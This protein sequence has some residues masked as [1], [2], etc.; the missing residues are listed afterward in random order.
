MSNLIGKIKST[1]ASTFEIP[2]ETIRDDSSS[3][4]IEKWDSIGQINLV[5]ALEQELGLSFTMDEILQLKD[6]ATICRVV[7]GKTA[8]AKTA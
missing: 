6:I 4:T 1:I 7:A 8:E 2:I 3:Q 5:M